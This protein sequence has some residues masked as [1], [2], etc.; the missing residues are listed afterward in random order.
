MSLNGLDNVTSIGGGI[1][2]LNDDG[3]INLSGLDNLTSISGGIQII[4]NLALGSLAGLDNVN[5]NT[6]DSL[7][8]RDNSLLA[9]CEVQSICDYLAIPN[10]I[11][12]IQDNAPGCNSQQQVQDACYTDVA[13][14]GSGHQ[15]DLVIIP[16]PLES[17]TL[18]EYKLRNNSPVT[19]KILDLS[20]REM[21]T[22]VNE[23]QQQGEQRIVF[24]T[25]GLKPGIYFC[26]M[27]TNEGIQTKKI[28][29]LH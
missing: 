28:I 15:N 19:L 1:L 13:E 14:I 10:G 21:A 9:T 12:V 16:N 2:I 25:P 11:I 8:I 27:K 23:V 4:Q 3:L 7:L 5:A 22:L 24:N 26:V 18:I 6:I 20:G 29:K 17:T